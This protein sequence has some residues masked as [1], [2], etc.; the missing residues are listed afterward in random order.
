MAQQLVQRVRWRETMEELRA[1]HPDI[2]V[3]IG[4]R[5]VLAGLARLNGFG[6][7]TVVR[8]VDSLRAAEQVRADHSAGGGK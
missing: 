1:L 3:E 7:E 2:L 8:G 5:R 6:D 4:P